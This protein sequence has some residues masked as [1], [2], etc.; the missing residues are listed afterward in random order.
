MKCN[1]CDGK[2]KRFLGLNEETQCHRC[3]GNGAIRP[4]GIDRPQFLKT[5]RTLRVILDNNHINPKNLYLHP[6]KTSCFCR[7]IAGQF[8]SEG[9]EIVV[10]PTHRGGAILSQ[11]VAFHL[12]EFTGKE[13]LSVCA[14]ENQQGHLDIPG[15]SRIL[16]GRNVLVV[17]DLLG[18]GSSAKR[19]IEAVRNLDG[20]LVGL[21][22]LCK[23]EVKPEE[24]GNPP[25]I[26]SLI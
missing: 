24:V 3:D 1:A 16:A 18:I 11:W 26:F 2:G 9:P 7:M 22:T 25:E 19:I 4:F 8:A 12:L 6:A 23:R 14:E 21:G 10:S 5:L 15:Y 17:E 13:V 20:N